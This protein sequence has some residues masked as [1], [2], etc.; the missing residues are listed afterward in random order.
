MLCVA[1]DLKEIY[2][3]DCS[4]E[5]KG[6]VHRSWLENKIDASERVVV[7]SNSKQYCNDKSTTL[8]KKAKEHLLHYVTYIILIKIN[9]TERNNFRDGEACF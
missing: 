6:L 1:Q 7:N 5:R 3:H 4:G 2:K 9:T 8:K